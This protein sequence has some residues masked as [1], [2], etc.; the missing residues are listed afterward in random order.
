MQQ[1]ESR[2]GRPFLTVW[3]G[4]TVSEI[5]SMLSGV[6]GAVYVFLET[7]SAAW[8]GLASGVAT[9]P[10]VLVGAA[11]SVIDRHSRRRVMIAGDLVAALA[12]LSLLVLALAGD[13]RVGHLVAAGFIGSIGNAVQSAAAQAAIPALVDQ[14]QLERA[15]ALKQLGAGIG[16]VIGPVAAT[17]ILVRWGIETVLIIDLVTFA[18]GVT[19]VGVVRFR[20]VAPTPQV[21]DDGSWRDMWIWLRGPGAVLVALLALS[22]TVNL[23]LAFFNVSILVATTVVG[24]PATAGMVLGIGGAAMIAGSLGT[25]ALGTSVDRAKRIAASLALVGIGFAVAGIR[26]SVWNQ[27]LGVAIALSAVPMISATAGAIFNER[28]PT[29]MQ[30]RVFALRGAMANGLQSAGS[31]VAGVLVVQVAEPAMATGVLRGSLGRVLGTGPSAGAALVLVGAGL[32]TI[33][34][35]TVVL[36]SNLRPALRRPESPH[37]ESLN[38]PDRGSVGSELAGGVRVQPLGVAVEADEVGVDAPLRELGDHG[39]ERCHRTGVPDAGIRQVD[40]DPIDLDG[41]VVERMHQIV[42]RCE[43][44]LAADVVQSLDVVGIHD[45]RHRHDV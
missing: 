43:E 15:H 32:V 12:P 30:G 33:V 28:V 44:Q 35:A 40:L 1:N 36:R 10:A 34:I 18:L 2:L 29:Q 6:A 13:L 19:A 25:A 26:P 14:D 4:Q 20:E 3:A 7:G 8:L 37:P 5:G 45:A 9:L 17:P 23:T 21:D 11:G 42:G 31:L 22:G 27:V 39:V 41:V 16:I 38:R 24:G